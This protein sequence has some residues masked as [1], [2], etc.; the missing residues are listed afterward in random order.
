MA[1]DFDLH[2]ALRSDYKTVVLN[3][4]AKNVLQ[5]IMH[6]PPAWE[7]TPYE[8]AQAGL[9][10]KSLKVANSGKKTIQLVTA[11]LAAHGY[12]LDNSCPHCGR[13]L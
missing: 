9:S 12:R 3:T 8:I 7:P 10:K 6:K 11:W 2:P 13:V 1:Y 5:N 4:R